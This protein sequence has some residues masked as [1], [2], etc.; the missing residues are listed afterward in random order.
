MDHRLFNQPAA[1]DKNLITLLE[2]MPS[3]S[4][5]NYQAN[6]KEKARFININI[7]NTD[8]SETAM[9]KVQKIMKF[10]KDN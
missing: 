7:E 2:R 6:I 9:T 5:R 4:D 3:D 10:Q 1:G 8:F